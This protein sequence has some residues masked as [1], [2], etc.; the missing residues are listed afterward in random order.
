MGNPII[1][2]AFFAVLAALSG[3][4]AGWLS[5]GRQARRLQMGAAV[6]EKCVK[7]LEHLPARI[8]DMDRKHASALTAKDAKALALSQRI[9]EL[10]P[11]AARA[12]ELENRLKATVADKDRALA[13]HEAAARRHA[14]EQNRL[15]AGMALV[16]GRLSDGHV[17]LEAARTG[18]EAR[19]AKLTARVQELEPHLFELGEMED[20]LHT[21][22]AARDAEI[23]HLQSRLAEE[24]RGAK[25]LALRLTEGAA[26]H[27]AQAADLGAGHQAE[28]A[29][30]S[31]THEARVA[32]LLASHEADLASRST[33]AVDFGAR[34]EAE[35]AEQ[36]AELRASHEADLA[37]RSA[38][39]VDLGARHHA[40]LAEQVAELRASHEADLARSSAQ[41]VDLGARHQA[42]LAEQV[43]ELRASHEAELASRSAQA[44]DLDARHQ[45][46]LAE[47]VAEMRINNEADLASRL[48]ERC[49]AHE[50]QVA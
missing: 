20:R 27:E 24:E 46:E 40:E 36:V 10:Q 15:E 2:N 3:L 5:W 28:L 11:V 43:A 12:P 8:E 6:L 17:E 26:A 33:Q 44:V 41:A 4:A 38:L 31:A 16:E 19:N 29:E 37:S 25:K 49:A 18:W 42:E 1:E 50:A 48:A 35:L 7:D 21:M 39:A 23:S 34:H 45:A 32:E 14:E 30:Q 47:R 13:Q 22:I 9:D